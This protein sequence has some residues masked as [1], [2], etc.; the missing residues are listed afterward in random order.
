MRVRKVAGTRVRAVLKLLATQAGFMLNPLVAQS[1]E[2]MPEEYGEVTR[3]ESM[4][5]G[6]DDG[7]DDSD[8]DE[9]D[10]DEDDHDDDNDD[11]DDDDDSDGDSDGDDDDDEGD[12]DD[13]SVSKPHPLSIYLPTYLPTYPSSTAL[14]VKTEDRLNKL[15]SYFFI[16]KND[17]FMDGN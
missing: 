5:K 6:D 3:A 11:D 12:S 13:D 16:A 2:S 4:L 9:G 1:V 8:D 14:G 17:T 7:D 15:V 10:S